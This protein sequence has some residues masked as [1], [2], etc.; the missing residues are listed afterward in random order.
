MTPEGDP[1]AGAHKCAADAAAYVLGALEPQEVE[2]FRRHLADCIVC[3]DEVAAL[4]QAVEVLP[5]AA[6]QFRAPPT[7]R[8]NVIRTVRE[9][10]AQATPSATPRSRWARAIPIGTSSPVPRP[11]LAALATVVLIAVVT[12][13]VLQLG[14]SG[15]ARVVAASVGSAVVRIDNGHAELIVNH[16]PPPPAGRIYELWLKRGNRQPTPTRT[17]FTVTATG[18]A[19]VGVPGRLSGATTV[20]VTPEPAGGSSTPTHAPVIVATVT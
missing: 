13:G 7:L 6:P 2:A 18:K 20:M 17:L 16:L 9:E 3:R 19:D 14:G 4:Q 10:A 12:L 1:M 8:A 11:A 5:A 15:G